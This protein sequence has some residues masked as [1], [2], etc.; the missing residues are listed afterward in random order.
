MITQNDKD[1]LYHKF[2]DANSPMKLDHAWEWYHRPQ[3]DFGNRMIER[4][5]WMV[6]RV[7]G[8]NVLDIGCGSGL[9]PVLWCGI[10]GVKKV[11][12]IDL[13]KESI[14]A[15]TSRLQKIKANVDIKF[16]VGFAEELQ[17]EDESFDTVV[18]GEVLEHVHD[19][20][21][22]LSEAHRVLRPGGVLIVSVPKG[23]KTSINHVRV[24]IPETFYQ[25][26]ESGSFTIKEF[27]K[28]HCPCYKWIGCR[29]IKNA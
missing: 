15:A 7:K 14:T 2:N 8:S 23:G 26:I 9:G 22:A 21:L 4:F 18:M 16:A 13:S 28:L 10:Q 29:A 24:Y 17:F 19:D 11:V 27:I 20:K 3:T 5:T 1:E 6:E 12:G 25:F